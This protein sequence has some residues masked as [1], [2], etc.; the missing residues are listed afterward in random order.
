MTRMRIPGPLKCK[1]IYSAFL[2][3]F[4]NYDGMVFNYQPYDRFSIRLMMNNRHYIFTYVNE[5]NWG[6]QTEKNY[7]DMAKAIR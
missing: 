4:P 2:L 5:K 7:L 1:E 3:L 6:L